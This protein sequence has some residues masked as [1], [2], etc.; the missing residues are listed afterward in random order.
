MIRLASARVESKE[1]NESAEPVGRG[2]LSH[3]NEVRQFAAL[4]YSQ[5]QVERASWTRYR[6]CG[7]AG[8][9]VD[10]LVSESCPGPPDRAARS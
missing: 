7:A 9:E 4:I 2:A 10:H 3:R 8:A 5:R 6:G 1:G